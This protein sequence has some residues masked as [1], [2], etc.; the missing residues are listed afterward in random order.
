MA[1]FRYQGYDRSGAKVDG[2]I[3]AVSVEVAK[4]KLKAD[5][6]LISSCK[7]EKEDVVRG[8][9]G[10]GKLSL[11]DITFLTSELSVLLDAGLKI[12]KGLELLKKSS[13]KPALRQ[14]LEKLT[15]SLRGGRQLS[16]ALTDYPEYFDPLYINLVSI[17]EASGQLVEAFRALS[18]DLAYRR[19]LQQKIVQ[20]LTYPA[21]ILLVCI[22]SILFI[23]NYVVPNMSSLFAGQEDLPGY[24]Q[25]LLGL[26]D[27]LINYQLWLGLALLVFGVVA[28]KY[29][30]PPGVKARLQ[31]L[32]LRVPGLRAAVLLVERIR[33][34]SG[35][36]M[37]L[38]AGISVDQALQLASGGVKN[39]L[40]QQEL[41]I[42][43]EKIK[44]GEPLAATLN[45]TAIFPDFFASLLAVGEE[46]GELERIFTEITNRSRRDFDNWVTR[47]TSLLEPLL[48]LVMGGIVGSVVVI[49]ML[50]ITN[51]TDIGI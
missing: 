21:V 46:S 16:Q 22:A 51:V 29:P 32:Q 17:G 45:R 20:A 44:R 49:M 26:S 4:D 33:F 9:L 1:Q 39:R 36:A 25:M 23:F 48:I 8:L 37:M 19:S 7:A 27:W 34:C 11:E 13:K 12:D 24:T 3:D 42:A 2:V 6:L 38:Q 50:S 31:Q 15:K 18:A 47:M 40:L 30:M 14:L 43:I 28:F 10:Q 35:L 41:W 5:G